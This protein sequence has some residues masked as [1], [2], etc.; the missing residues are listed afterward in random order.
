MED[1]CQAPIFIPSTESSCQ[2]N[3]IYLW[4]KTEGGMDS[5]LLTSP[6]G[7]PPPVSVTRSGGDVT[8]GRG[9]MD[10]ATGRRSAPQHCGIK[11]APLSCIDTLLMIQLVNISKHFQGRYLFRDISWQL[12]DGERVGLCGP[13]GCGKTTLLRMLAGQA[14]PDD[15]NLAYPKGTTIGYLPQDVV[16][17]AGHTLME[18]M[19]QAF[20]S[21]LRLLEEQTELEQKMA[22][23]PHDDPDFLAVTERYGEVQHRFRENGGYTMEGQIA[24]VLLGLGFAQDDFERDCS[25]FSGGWQMRIALARLLLTKPDVLLLDEPTNHLDIEARSWLEEFLQTYPYSVIL[26]SHDRYFLDAVVHR[27]TEVSPLGLLDF[28]GGY[29]A[30]LQQRD[31]H[32]ARLESQNERLRKEIDRFQTLVNR[33]G[34]KATKAAQANSWRKQIEK[35]E[36]D[37]VPL[38]PPRD[39]ISF[40]FPS[41]PR[42]GK[43]ALTVHG[44]AKSYGDH[45]VFRDVD[46]ILE[47][48]QRVALAGVNGAGKSTLMRILAGDKPDAGEVQLG[49]NVVS[50]YFAQDQSHTLDMSRTVYEEAAVEAPSDFIPRLRN[51]LG[52]FL[53]SGD[54]VEKPVGVLSGGERNRLALLKL[55]LQPTNLLLLDEPTNHLDIDSKDMLLEALKLYEGTVV[56]VSHDRYF[57]EQLATRVIE[58]GDGQATVHLGDYENFLWKKSRQDAEQVPASPGVPSPASASS[59]NTGHLAGTQTIPGD[60]ASPQTAGPGDGM[61]EKQRRMAERE[62]RKAAQ[63]A[64]RTRRKRIESIEARIAETEAKI[65]ELETQLSDP[66]HF[67]DAEK[68]AAL[69]QELEAARSQEV[70]LLAEW[71]AAHEDP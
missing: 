41:A 69:S 58:V 30:Y 40:R 21:L 68:S 44:V 15:G 70:N 51:L 62:E 23:L 9:P 27:I 35:L 26:V 47:R 14:P 20:A 1:S 5:S 46:F 54:D 18:E 52:A 71:E 32:I 17:L 22:T 67:S 37:L 25:E 11:P 60:G 42:S 13:N 3:L 43:V 28:T 63:V 48:G 49:H 59:L 29:T 34:A 16:G 66:A 39:T 6:S 56:F 33:F 31:A 64:E 7:P 50:S 19:R 2:V 24:H 4:S 45:T 53:F 55:L 10:A 65:E 61:N 38:P 12:R 36:A 57:V 8:C